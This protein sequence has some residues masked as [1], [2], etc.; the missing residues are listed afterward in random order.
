MTGNNDKK[1]CSKRRL[2]R[3]LYMALSMEKQ[4][5]IA[6]A[7]MREHLQNNDPDG[8]SEKLHKLIN[9]H[10]KTSQ[11]LQDTLD[12]IENKDVIE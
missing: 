5:T 7:R 11:F 10:D 9:E 1:P 6:A 2:I 8:A 12:L 4:N 3:R